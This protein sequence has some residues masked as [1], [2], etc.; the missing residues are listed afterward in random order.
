M[1]L[2]AYRYPNLQLRLI[3]FIR[4]L[5][6]RLFMDLM[7]FLLLQDDLLC[8]LLVHFYSFSLVL[9]C[10]VFCFMLEASLLLLVCSF[11]SQRYFVVWC[12]FFILLNI[13]LPLRL[14]SPL[15]DRQIVGLKQKDSVI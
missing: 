3:L 10:L 12:S 15:P 1:L 4:L 11:L 13:M 6:S 7:L 2:L 5:R 14:F 8:Y 9:C